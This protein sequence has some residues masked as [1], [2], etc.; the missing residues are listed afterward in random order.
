MIQDRERSQWAEEGCSKLLGNRPSRNSC[1]SMTW[2]ITCNGTNARDVEKLPSTVHYH[3]NIGRS[4]SSLFPPGMLHPFVSHKKARLP[5]Q[6]FFFIFPWI[7][8]S[9]SPPQWG[10]AAPHAQH[11]GQTLAWIGMTLRR[12]SHSKSP[13]YEKADADG[14]PECTL[15]TPCSHRNN[16]HI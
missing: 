4:L 8:I 15:G 9:S 2:S 7:I 14:L 5:V 16:P 11:A 12:M 1:K 6:P 13:T 3:Q 10:I